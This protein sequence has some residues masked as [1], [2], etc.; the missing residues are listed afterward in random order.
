MKFSTG[1]L[2]LSLV[3][4]VNGINSLTDLLPTKWKYWAFFAVSMLAGAIQVLAHISNPDGTSAN[5][6]QGLTPAQLEEYR[7][8]F[9]SEQK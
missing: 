7:K 5:L 8:L 2:G 9:L 1:M 6:P 4:V 3:A